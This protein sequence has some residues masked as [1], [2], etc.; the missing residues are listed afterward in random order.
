MRRMQADHGERG[1]A[2]RGDG[3]RGD[4]DAIGQVVRGEQDMGDHQD[5]GRIGDAMEHMPSVVRQAP[6]NPHA[7][8]S[9]DHQLERDDAQRDVELA[10][11]RHEL[12]QRRHRIRLLEQVRHRMQRGEAQRHDGQHHVRAERPVSSGAGGPAAHTPDAQHQHLFERLVP[13]LQVVVGQLGGQG[14]RPA[15]GRDTVPT[16]L[17]PHPPE[18]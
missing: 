5:V 9:D 2:C 1:H 14:R 6:L 11:E 18:L 16:Q 15:G 12:P 17:R 10:H 7:D 4:H 8:R 3:H 13:V